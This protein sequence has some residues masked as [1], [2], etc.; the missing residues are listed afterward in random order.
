MIKSIVNTF[1]K[2]AEQHKLVRSFKYD[3][4]S[5]GG[6]V[7]EDKYPQL[8]LEDSIFVDNGSITGGNVSI[9]I[10]FDVTMIP[11]AFENYN[12][13]QL[14]VEECQTVSM[15]IALNV[16]AKL[17]EIYNA[18]DDKDNEGMAEMSIDRYNFMTLR[19]WYDD[20]ASGVR[21]TLNLK[22]ANPI[23]FCDLDE[24]FD[25]DKEFDLGELLSPIDTDGAYG[26]VEFDYKF[27]KITL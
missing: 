9:T 24:H 5:K 13:R 7:G 21:C 1:Y 27:P 20:D 23:Q 18:Y 11:Q 19:H 26:C 15:E 12:V 14:S 8:F 17:R 2:V 22:M 3:R 4:V 16:I 10:N 6:G 25:K